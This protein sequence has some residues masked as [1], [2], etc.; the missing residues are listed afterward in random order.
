[1][2]HEDD[3]EHATTFYSLEII[4]YIIYAAF[5]FKELLNNHNKLRATKFFMMNKYCIL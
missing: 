3:H 4:G 5:I 1:M 2:E